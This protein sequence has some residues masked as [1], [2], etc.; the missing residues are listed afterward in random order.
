MFFCMLKK[1]KN[2]IENGSQA[3]ESLYQKKT[4]KRVK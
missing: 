4:S 1:E 3:R 2:E